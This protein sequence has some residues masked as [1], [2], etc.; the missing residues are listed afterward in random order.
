MDDRAAIVRKTGESTTNMILAVTEV[1]NTLKADVARGYI[2]S[3]VILI[4]VFFAGLILF[5]VLERLFPAVIPVYKTGPRRRGYLAD[6]T[7]SMVEGPVLSSL[8]KIAAYGVVIQFP[9]LVHSGLSVWP[10]WLQFV[11][12]LIVNDFARYWLHRWHHKYDWMWRIHRVHHTAVE[13][14]A[15]STFRVHVLEAAIKYGL[16]V[17]PFHLL[18][19]DRNVILIYSSIDILKGFWH[20][21][22][23]RTR[24]GW[25]NYILNSAELHWWHHSVEAKGQLAN[26][27]SILSIWDWLFG[28]AYYARGEWP[29][30]IGVAG[31]ERFP[32]TYYEQMATAFMTDEEVIEKFGSAAPDAAAKPAAPRPDSDAKQTAPRTNAVRVKGPALAL[33]EAAGP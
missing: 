27:G 14:D 11:V 13:M 9:A 30:R 2:P 12:F 5:H 4:G 29:D 22:N 1:L 24:I 25:L 32:D 21:A 6:F 20:H 28:T 33:P 16:I 3:I 10:W 7:A 15:M 31:M 8:T 26:Y 17:L 19:V 18:H 23:I